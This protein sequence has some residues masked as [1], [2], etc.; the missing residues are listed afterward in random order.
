MYSPSFGPHAAAF[1]LSIVHARQYC[2]PSGCDAGSFIRRLG[3]IA[4]LALFL[5]SPSST[6][7]AAEC[8][9]AD[10]TGTPLNYRLSP[11][12]KVGG[13][14]PNGLTVVMTDSEEGK[15]VQV[16]LF[17]GDYIG[18]VYK[19][20]LNCRAFRQDGTY[21]L[22]LSLAEARGLGLNYDYTF[23]AGEECFII[24]DGLITLRILPARVAAMKEKGI[25]FDVL[26]MIARVDGFRYHPETG[27]RLPT[28]AILE[29]LEHSP[30]EIPIIV[31]DCL[32][33]GK[34][35]L[36]RA[37]YYAYLS[38][39]TCDVAFNPFTGAAVSDADKAILTKQGVVVDGGAGPSPSEAS[40]A[41]IRGKR[42]AT[43]KQIEELRRRVGQ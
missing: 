1:C 33:G 11:G 13:T 12:G 3:F 21:P 32:R 40:L 16:A 15:W 19:D 17:R 5:W 25:P 38:L 35:L 43:K 36:D 41:S 34:V 24:G 14:L 31:P 10:P 8:V 18:Y 39:Q 30:T 4:L 27:K 20:Y 7:F 2:V 22:I 9:V 28:I 6:V 23:N 42:A 37:N 29:Y 26:C